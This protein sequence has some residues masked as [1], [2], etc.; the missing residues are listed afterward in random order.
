MT[1]ET[2]LDDMRA[3]ALENLRRAVETEGLA[4]AEHLTALHGL[5]LAQ[6]DALSLGIT[7]PALPLGQGAVPVPDLSGL[8]PN[9]RA[10]VSAVV[11]Q[12]PDGKPFYQGVGEFLDDVGVYLVNN[13]H[14][15]ATSRTLR[16]LFNKAKLKLW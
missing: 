13:G 5:R 6:I 16:R 12:W 2:L 10:K 7:I 15:P 1:G 4:A 8:K 11:A 9:E 3:L 14:S